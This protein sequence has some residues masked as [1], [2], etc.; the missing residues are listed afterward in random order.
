[1]AGPLLPTA[2]QDPL[3]DQYVGGG[4]LAGNPRFYD[5]ANKGRIQPIIGVALTTGCLMRACGVGASY[6]TPWGLSER[7]FL[8]YS[9]KQ[10]WFS[11]SVIGMQDLACH[12]TFPLFRQAT[13]TVSPL[14]ALSPETAQRS[15]HSTLSWQLPATSGP[16]TTC[17]LRCGT[18]HSPCK[19]SA[20]ASWP[21]GAPW[22]GMINAMTWWPS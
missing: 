4:G 8:S 10:G 15:A 7:P 16:M 20:V 11:A 2:E 18:G 17:L 9:R 5:L 1:M 19:S 14:T 21:H 6:A 12:D 13:L 22:D 3:A